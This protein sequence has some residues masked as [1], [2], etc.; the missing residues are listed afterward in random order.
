ME[1]PSDHRHKLDALLQP[2]NRS[3]APG[4]IV[5]I[6]HRGR[7][8][9]RRGFGLASVQQAQANTPLTRMRIGSTSKHFTCLSTLLLA[10]EGQLDIDAPLRR[11][12]PELDGISG[13]PTLRECMLHTSGL[14]DPNDLLLLLLNKSWNNFPAPGHL[15]QVGRRIA[16]LNYPRGE[17]MIYCNQG[18]HLLSRM[19]ERVSGMAYGEFLRER[20]LAPM[21]MHDTA[22]L[23]SD[24]ALLPRL[25]DLHLKDGDGWRRGLFPSEELLGEGGMVSTV[26]DMLTWLAH[27]RSPDKIVGSAVSWE[28]MLR[29]PRYSSGAEGD[30]CLGLLRERWRGVEIVH[31]AGGVIGGNS[32]MLT[33]PAHELDVIVLC[34]RN[35][36]ASP[37]LA[38]RIVEALLGETL[39]P[40]AAPARR[41]GLI[42]RW[43]AP[44]SHRLIG[45]L[46]T[47]L[48]GDTEASLALSVQG[49]TMGAVIERD[50][51]WI[52][53]CSPHG[54]IAITLPAE[55]QPEV[56]HGSDSGHAET[57]QRLPDSGPAAEAL[58]ADLVGRYRETDLGVEVA[59]LLI[60]GALHLD[61]LPVS[62][63]SRLRLT[64][65]TM[66]VCGFAYE[67]NGFATYPVAGSLAI[68]R[69]EGRVTGLWLNGARTRNLWLQRHV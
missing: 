8:I 59:I 54:R 42:G 52:M 60:D 12:L 17:R 68:E 28:Q 9:Y 36:T 53:N 69:Q 34:N 55:E 51:Q 49:Q 20:V 43:Y 11:Y 50:G 32:Q 19:I 14:R 25:A 47:P 33:V 29:K 40:A 62:G 38:N 27:L 10:E 3:D 30:Y 65:Y 41:P 39:E 57:W 44:A 13:A 67:S 2:W 23:A 56:L 26:D 35:D 6:A 1:L 21:G 5:G 61:L 37:A 7:T 64:P 24:H 63:H 18:Y 15:L 45:L 46:E 16:S 4:F 58:A 48:P 66:D 22:L 31:H